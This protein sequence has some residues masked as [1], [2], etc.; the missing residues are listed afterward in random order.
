MSNKGEQ[1]IKEMRL[2]P[3]FHQTRHSTFVILTM[4]K[5]EMMVQTCPIRKKW[6]TKEMPLSN[7]SK[8]GVLTLSF[9]NRASALKYLVNLVELKNIEHRIEQI[10]RYLFILVKTN[11]W[12]YELFYIVYGLPGVRIKSTLVCPSCFFTCSNRSLQKKM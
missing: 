4:D 7:K 6:M 2:G 8:R 1:Q 10:H 5:V 3:C 9:S 12:K 11:L